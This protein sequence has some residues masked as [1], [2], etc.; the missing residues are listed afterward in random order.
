MAA[1][2][3]TED[4]GDSPVFKPKQG[5]KKEK[6]LINT[7]SNKASFATDISDNEDSPVFIPTQTKKK[8]KRERILSDSSSD[9]YQFD[10]NTSLINIS[11]IQ[12]PNSRSKYCDESMNNDS[13]FQLTSPAVVSSEVNRRKDYNLRS[14]A[15]HLNSPVLKFKSSMTE[16]NFEDHLIENEFGISSRTRRRKFHCVSSP[17]S[18]NDVMKIDTRQHVDNLQR[19]WTVTRT[20]ANTRASFSPSDI[21]PVIGRC[22]STE[23]KGKEFIG[24]YPNRTEMQS[25]WKS[26]YQT[27][28]NKKTMKLHS[29]VNDPDSSNPFN[30]PVTH[31]NVS[32]TLHLTRKY[33][34]RTV[35][36]S[37]KAVWN[38]GND[39]S[40]SKLEHE[41]ALSHAAV[42]YGRSRLRKLKNERDTRSAAPFEL[43]Q[44]LVADCYAKS[45]LRGDSNDRKNSKICKSSP[46]RKH[47]TSGS[48]FTTP[49]KRCFSQMTSTT[50]SYRLYNKENQEFETADQLDRDL[51]IDFIIDTPQREL[52]C[53]SILGRRQHREPKNDF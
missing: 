25:K 3:D 7:N 50:P 43:E 6:W 8:K 28:P 35:S 24:E 19:P 31:P 16:C 37:S 2:T 32:P 12:S 30:F 23:R 45:L 22:Q 9:S 11:D 14:V 26:F 27:S 33:P 51:S 42:N 53:K 18:E 29:N 15:E 52:R 20:T 13:F 5:I 49:F 21:S 10:G 34:F 48:N 38:T 1:L 40:E 47:Q 46:D 39:Q 36:S 17:E 44:S 4:E 41:S